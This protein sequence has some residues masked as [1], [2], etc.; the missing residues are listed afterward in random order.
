[1]VRVFQ[2]LKKDRVSQ[3]ELTK[4]LSEKDEV[5]ADLRSEGE[6]LSKQAGKHS[7]IIKKLRSKEK[8]LEKELTSTKSGLEEKTKVSFFLHLK[9][10]HFVSAQWSV[11]VK[12]V[13]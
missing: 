13:Q 4:L 6:S 2:V 12:N 5:I 3:K 11:F 1:M 8:S 10:K 7:E 9:A